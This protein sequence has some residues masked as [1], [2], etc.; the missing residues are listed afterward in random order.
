MARVAARSML[1]AGAVVL[2][3]VAVAVAWPVPTQEEYDASGRVGDDGSPPL[4]FVAIGD[5]STTGPG[6]S[7]PG[8]IWIR[9]V[10]TDLSDRFTVEL[11]SFAVGG[12]KAADLLDGQLQAAEEAA[13]DISFVAVGANDAL[14]GMSDQAFE[15]SLDEIVQRLVAVSPLVVLSGVGDLGTVPRALPPLDLM[16]RARGRSIDRLQQRVADRHGAIKVDMWGL[17]T[18]QFRTRPELFS[19]DR[20]HP[21]DAGH[22]VWADAVL[23]TLEPHLAGLDA[24]RPG[25]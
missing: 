24:G 1:A 20:F 21:S 17:T 22:R 10:A 11:R 12:S 3:E 5:S 9:Q 18:H 8:A 14:K 13:A 6:T 16:I 25:R 23:A 4:R 15:R 2:G 7:G 19:G